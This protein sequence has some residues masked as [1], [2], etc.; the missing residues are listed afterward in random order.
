M[1]VTQNDEHLE[2]ILP[3][4]DAEFRG[5]F[6]NWLNEAVFTK[7][8]ASASYGDVKKPWPR[9]PHLAQIAD[10]IQSDTFIV[11]PKSRRMMISWI[12][13]AYCVWRARYFPGSAIFWQSETEAKSTWTLENRCMYIEDNL[14]WPQMRQ[15][16]RTVVTHKGTAGRIYYP[17]GSYIWGISEGGDVLR[18]YTASVLVMDELEFQPEGHDSMKAAMPLIEKGTQAIAIS[19]PNGPPQ[20]MAKLC[21][22]IGFMSWRDFKRQLALRVA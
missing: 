4:L 8:E 11:L 16:L 22:K 12:A 6:A 20:P 15:P 7:D 3:V 2:K 5:R 9:K 18:A 13:A 10:V 14:R 1:T 19:T 17:N 21:R